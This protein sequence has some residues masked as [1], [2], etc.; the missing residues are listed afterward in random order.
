VTI[1]T[2][3]DRRATLLA[4]CYVALAE[5]DFDLRAWADEVYVRSVID[6]RGHLSD[7]DEHTPALLARAAA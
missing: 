2:D 3:A 7:F 5:V 1:A 6:G 4:R